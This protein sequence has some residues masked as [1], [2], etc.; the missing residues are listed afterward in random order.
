MTMA[1]SVYK[2]W[3][4]GIGGIGG[5][6]LFFFIALA[7]AVCIFVDSSNRGLRVPSWRAGAVVPFVFFLPTILFRFGDL[8]IDPQASEWFLVLGVLATAICI[9]AAV[10]YFATYWGQQE[11]PVMNVSPQYPLMPEPHQ[12]AVSQRSP[13]P[14]SWR[15]PLPQTS[16]RERVMAWLVDQATGRQYQ[17]FKG[18]TRVGR[19]EQVN[20]IVLN[21][22]T[23]SREHALI[24]ESNGVYTIYDRGSKGG[25]YV[26]SNR[27]R[28]PTII[29]HGDVIQL[30]E[31]R[32]LF[33]STQQ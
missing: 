23:V 30:G 27:I 13:E 31:T 8:N 25:T 21:D 5:W 14:I 16:R 28:Q 22:P 10:G 17:L 12:P 2:W 18:D 11:A 32:L 26:N 3:Y 1:D 15:Q 24:R 20:D 19:K 4:W 33:M 6:L 7:A 29:Y 9:A